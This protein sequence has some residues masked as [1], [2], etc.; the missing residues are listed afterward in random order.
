MVAKLFEQFAFDKVNHYLNENYI[1]TNRQFSFR[2][3]HSTLMSLFNAT[4]NWL[5]DIDQWLINGVLFVDLKKAFDTV[6]HQILINEL[7]LC[8]INGMALK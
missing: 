8:G 4:S 3:S 7:K 5:L 2:K 1:L 6:D